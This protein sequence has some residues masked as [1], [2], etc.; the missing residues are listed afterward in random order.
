MKFKEKLVKATTITTTLIAGSSIQAY[1]GMEE[2]KIDGMDNVAS[3]LQ[4]FIKYI[5]LFFI[6]AGAVTAFY[7]AYKLFQSIKSQDSDSRSS[8]VLEI[9]SGLGAIAVGTG[10]SIFSAYIRL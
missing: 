7:G 6:A 10:A 3:S 5:G 2:L 1:A 4:N 8:A 9:A